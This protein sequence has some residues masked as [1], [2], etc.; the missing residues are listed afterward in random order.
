MVTYSDIKVNPNLPKT[1]LEL[2][3]PSGVKREKPQK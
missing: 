2:Q 3:L 1:A